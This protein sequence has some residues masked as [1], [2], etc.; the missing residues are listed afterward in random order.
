MLAETTERPALQRIMLVEDDTAL[1]AMI[2]KHLRARGFVVDE[3]GEAEGEATDSLARKGSYDLLIT[4]LHLPGMSGTELTRM[5]LTQQP[6]TPV[7]VITGDPEAARESRPFSQGRVTYLLKPFALEDLDGAIRDAVARFKLLRAAAAIGHEGEKPWGTST[8]LTQIPAGWL[9]EVD[10]QSGAG[11][12]HGDRVS[13]IAGAIMNAI[14]EGFPSEVRNAV[15]RASSMH[16][17]GR[18]MGISPRP[19]DLACCSAQLLWEMKVDPKVVR[20]VRHMHERWDGT[21]GPDG[22]KGK[23]IPATSRILAAADLI[24][25]RA[26]AWIGA[27]VDAGDALERAVFGLAP[28]AEEMFGPTVAGA[29]TKAIPEIRWTSNLFLENENESPDFDML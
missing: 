22:L 16:E 14:D 6:M 9:R 26:S 19:V 13:L 15:E 1:R 8:T 7:V 10:E 12:G 24:D 20:A 4:D 5:A 2:G 3:R 18:V 11:V 27:G 21:G 25:H 28:K 23:E 29:L 17:I